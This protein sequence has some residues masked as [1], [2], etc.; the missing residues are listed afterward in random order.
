VDGYVDAWRG[1]F[2]RPGGVYMGVRSVVKGWSHER[3]DHHHHHFVLWLSS[4]CYD[5][6]R[7]VLRVMAENLYYD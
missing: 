5:P 4:L 6:A 2:C 3:G 1:V 7:T